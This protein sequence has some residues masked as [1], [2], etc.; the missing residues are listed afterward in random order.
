MTSSPRRGAT[1]ANALGVS[2]KSLNVLLFGNEMGRR[3]VNA[4]LY[5][6]H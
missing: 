2:G 3:M 1:V 4:S 6:R 5:L